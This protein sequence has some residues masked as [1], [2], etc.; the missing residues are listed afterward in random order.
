M[1]FTTSSPQ[2]DAGRSSRPG[3]TLIELLVVIAIIAILAAMLLPSLASAKAKA[4]RIQ[5][6]SNLHQ[7]IIAFNLYGTDNHDS[8]P[9]G[10]DDP[11]GMWMV[12]LRQYYSADS[13]RLCPMATKLRSDL[14]ASVGFFPENSVNVTTFAWGAFGTN[15][16]PGGTPPRWSRPGLYGSYGVNGWV[17][18]PPPGA[19]ILTGTG[20]WKT[21][22]GAGRVS[23]VPVFA[24]CM[25]DGSRTFETDP[26][27]SGPGIDSGQGGMQD[28]ALPRHAGK[29]PV[30]IVFADSSARLVGLK[31]L[32]RL[33]W[34]PAFNT[35]YADQLNRWPKWMSGYQ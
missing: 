28:F 26:P 9:M 33:H 22:T 32:Y 10:W 29:R 15:G 34:S 14:P 24:D 25:Y 13:I 16:Y 8:M 12:A 21:M 17:H 18:N 27:P 7:W 3:F 6:T 4:K 1:R 5:C 35:S 20:Y 30:M 11:D 19:M 23:D 2:R 31:E